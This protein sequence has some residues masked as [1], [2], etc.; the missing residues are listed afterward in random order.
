MTAS[1]KAR[2]PVPAFAVYVRVGQVTN[3]FLR[4]G[5][6]IVG[7]NVAGGTLFDGRFFA[8]QQLGLQLVGNGF[9]DFALNGKNIGQIAIVGLRR[10]AHHCAHR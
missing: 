6:E 8:W 9:G 4:T 5:I 1:C 7:K 10:D 3:E 2:S